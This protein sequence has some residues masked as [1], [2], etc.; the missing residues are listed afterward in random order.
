MNE[1]T[2]NESGSQL[3]REAKEWKRKIFEF[4]QWLLEKG[5]AQTTLKARLECLEDSSV[6]L[7]TLLHSLNKIESN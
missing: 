2:E 3:L 6:S 5:I 7:I 4:R 1:L